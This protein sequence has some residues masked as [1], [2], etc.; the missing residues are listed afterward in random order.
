MLVAR[1]KAARHAKGWAL[2]DNSTQE[3]RIESKLILKLQSVATAQVRPMPAAP[4]YVT[5]VRHRLI[6][7]LR[8]SCGE[9]WGKSRRLRAKRSVAERLSSA[10]SAWRMGAFRNL[11]LTRTSERICGLAAFRFRVCRNAFSKLLQ[12]IPKSDLSTY[13]LCLMIYLM[14]YDL[15]LI[16][17]LMTYVLCLI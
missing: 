8:T 9:C 4:T 3:D 2:Q 14:S 6:M 17:C 1:G 7:R 13:V 15:C 16:L 10:E 11:R 12:A 5:D